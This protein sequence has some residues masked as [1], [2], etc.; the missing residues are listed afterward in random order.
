MNHNFK[1]LTNLFNYVNIKASHIYHARVGKEWRFNDYCHNFNRMYIVL[2]G[3]GILFNEEENITMSP[4]NIYVIPANHKYSCRCDDHLEKFFIHFSATILPQNDLLSD[5]KSIVTIPSSDTEI[6]SIRE[7]L[8]S[9][10]LRSALML[11]SFIRS[12]IIKITDPDTN[13]IAR[14][15]E[16]YRRYEKLYKYILSLLFS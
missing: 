9:E 8:Y 6:Q 4:G 15:I 12:I 13:H 3:S 11:Q 16:V 1:Q 14:D 7:M 2:D 5:T 10:T